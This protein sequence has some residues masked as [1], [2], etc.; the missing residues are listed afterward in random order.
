[1]S[2]VPSGALTGTPYWVY[3]AAWQL[4]YYYNE[5]SDQ[6]VCQDGRK[7]SRPP[8][9]SRESLIAAR[10]V[11]RTIPP[12]PVSSNVQWESPSS[13][14][15]YTYSSGRTSQS[16]INI[17]PSNYSNPKPLT[18][19]AYSSHSGPSSSAGSQ[20][21]S[22]TALTTIFEPLSISGQNR[23]PRQIPVTRNHNSLHGNIPQYYNTAG[24]VRSEPQE[25][26][27]NERKLY[28]STTSLTLSA[29]KCTKDAQV[30]NESQN[31]DVSSE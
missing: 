3:S 4:W 31:Q 1:M 29:K 10:R 17:S 20:P 5:H 6:I 13:M 9:L 14:E 26:P 25:A 23:T 15:S 21:F 8:Q 11:P 28:A 18:P 27:E 7:F 19:G 12:Y 22:P 2:G 24:T 30:S 16:D